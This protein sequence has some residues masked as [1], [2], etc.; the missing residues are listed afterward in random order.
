VLA[1]GNIQ[2]AVDLTVLAFDLA[3]KYRS[4]VVVL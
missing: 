4:I 3:E 2:E 1:P